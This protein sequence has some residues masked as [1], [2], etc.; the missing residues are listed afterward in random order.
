MSEEQ[1][2]VLIDQKE[3]GERIKR[4]YKKQTGMD[5]APVFLEV[6]TNAVFDYLEEKD[7][8]EVEEEDL[9]ND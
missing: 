9:F 5:L 4:D 7:I 1:N 6:I 3:M 2:E 8:F